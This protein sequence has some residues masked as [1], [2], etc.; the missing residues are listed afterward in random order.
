MTCELP[1]AAD[2]KRAHDNGEESARVL[3]ENERAEFE[4]R[5]QDSGQ[6]TPNQSTP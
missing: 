4:R 5:I 1:R 2:G 6:S 3:D